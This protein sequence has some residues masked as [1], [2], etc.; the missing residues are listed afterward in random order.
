[1]IKRFILEKEELLDDIA[2]DMGVSKSKL[3]YGVIEEELEDEEIVTDVI[4][5]RCF[6]NSE[7][8]KNLMSSVTK[9]YTY[10]DN[11]IQIE[12]S[13]LSNYISKLYNVK[14]SEVYDLFE[15]NI[16]GDMKECIAFELI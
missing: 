13:D 3:A 4:E 12:L 9:H 1:M 2:K 6:Y 7:I 16:F 15:S 14:V 11:I 10:K 8:V 5:I